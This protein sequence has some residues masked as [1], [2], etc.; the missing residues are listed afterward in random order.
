MTTYAGAVLPFGVASK[1]GLWGGL[2]VPASPFDA[3]LFG[4]VGQQP[5]ECRRDDQQPAGQRDRLALLGEP[6]SPVRTGLVSPRPSAAGK[7]ALGNLL[8]TQMRQV[9]VWNAHFA[10]KTLSAV[11]GAERWRHLACRPGESADHLRHARVAPAQRLGEPRWAAGDRSGFH[12][13]VSR[14][15]RRRCRSLVGASWCSGSNPT[16]QTA[17]WNA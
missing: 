4:R 11:I 2:Q 3:A 10:P 5:T 6:G 16:G 13:P 9:E 15:K 12:L 17:G 7:I 8:S 1:S 14:T